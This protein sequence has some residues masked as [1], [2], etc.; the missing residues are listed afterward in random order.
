[1]PTSGTIAPGWQIGQNDSGK[2]CSW[3]QSPF[4][5]NTAASP[6][7]HLG[8]TACGRPCS[9]R[10]DGSAAAVFAAVEGALVGSE[11][12]AERCCSH[13][14]SAATHSQAYRALLMA[15]VRSS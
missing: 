14:P 2:P 15:S 10:P 3:H 4:D 1:A 9:Q 12:G 7:V 5:W 6:G 13:P 11:V 8:Q